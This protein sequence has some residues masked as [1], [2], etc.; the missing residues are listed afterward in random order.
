MRRESPV[1]EWNLG[2]ALN[3]WD[4]LFDELEMVS[5]GFRRQKTDPSAKFDKQPMFNKAWEVLEG[6]HAS[7]P[8]AVWH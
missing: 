6:C 1:Y 5:R 8:L 3:L 7:L 4:T 2:T